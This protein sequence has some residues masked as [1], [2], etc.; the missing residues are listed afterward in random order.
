MRCNFQY[1]RTGATDFLMVLDVY[2]PV[3]V[4]H[5]PWKLRSRDIAKKAK[6]SSARNNAKCSK[7]FQFLCNY[8]D[9]TWFFNAN[10]RQV[11]REVL[12][13][14]ASSLGFQQLSR[15]LENV[16]AWKTMFD[17]YIV[18]TFSCLR[19]WN[20]LCHLWNWTN[21]LLNIGVCLK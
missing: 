20:G 10:I 17:P 21:P 12:K 9:R 3:L 16:N 18:L 7:F 8:S 14:A 19:F 13:T 4:R 1:D 15:D 6:Q 2:C 11:P 5:S